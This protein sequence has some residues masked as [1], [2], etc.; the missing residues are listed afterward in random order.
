MGPYMLKT[1]DMGQRMMKQS[2]GLQVNLDFCDEADCMRKLR[3][4]QALA[5]LLYGLFANPP[6]LD[7]QPSGFLSTR[8]EI[9]SRT[10]PDRTGLLSFLDNPE[11]GFADYVAYALEVP[12]Y[13]IMRE[14]RYIDLTQR[15]FRFREYLDSGHAG[16]RATMSDWNLHLSTL[17]TEVRLRPQIEVRCADSLP[18]HL[19]LTVAALIKGLMYDEQAFQAAWELCRMDSFAET[20]QACREAWRLGLKVP[21]KAGTLQD[22]ARACLDLAR[23]GLDRQQQHRG[24]DKSESR[25]LDGL[26]GLIEGGVTLAEQLLQNWQGSRQQKLMAVIRHCGFFDVR[27]NSHDGNCA[28]TQFRTTP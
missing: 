22:L 21:W 1:G 13:F 8:G 12:M 26:D 18:P 5:P 3:L 24:Q 6:L 28:N 27:S 10:D 4:A 19:V 11:A 23:N 7:G 15:P 17:F 25:F 20:G 9:W 16:H 14:G 2:A